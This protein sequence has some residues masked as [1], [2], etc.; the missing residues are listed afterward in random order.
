MERVG[1]GGV[2]LGSQYWITH[3]HDLK[4]GMA[5][6]KVVQKGVIRRTDSA[7]KGTS[8]LRYGGE[9]TKNIH[10]KIPP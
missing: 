5:A 1:G 4:K 9:K 7:L 8:L 10:Q 2:N 6:H 3:V